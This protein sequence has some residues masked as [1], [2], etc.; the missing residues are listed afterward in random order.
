MPAGNLLAAAAILFCGGSYTKFS[1]F[2]DILKLQFMS[3]STFYRIQDA[4]LIPV[5][6]ETWQKHQ[7]SLLQQFKV[8]PVSLL[9]DGRCDS[10]G[11][12]AKYGTYTHLEQNTGLIL[13]F[14]LVQ[15]SEVKNSVSME[16]EGFER[17]IQKLKSEGVTIAQIATDRH[18][19]ITA[20]MKKEYTDIKHQYDVW[21]VSK[22]VVKKLTKKGKA[23]GCSK[24][25]PWIQSISN[26]MWWSSESCNRDAEILKD[27]W[28]SIVHHSVNVHSWEG[29]RTF[30]KCEHPD[31]SPE[32]CRKK[33]SGS[34]LAPYHMKP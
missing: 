23:R 16:R 31:L 10:P 1:Q 14:Q 26:H 29:A 3:E 22:G 12:S 17:S 33:N 32:E 21:H 13:D 20:I 5:I 15:V 6:N 19:Q 9:G 4:A 24:L 8:A 7:A 2:A 30:V 11:Y 18:P 28:T 27:K 25:L 34:S